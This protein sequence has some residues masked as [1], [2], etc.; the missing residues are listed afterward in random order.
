MALA[1]EAAELMEPFLW[2]KSAES[3]ELDAKPGLREQVEEEI[4]PTSSSMP[5][6]FANIAHIDLATAIQ[7]KTPPERPEVSRRKGP[8]AGR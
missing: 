1:A 2:M 7:R 6:E 5:L 3:M 8:W 4:A